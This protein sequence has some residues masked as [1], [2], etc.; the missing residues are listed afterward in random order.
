MSACEIPS[1]VVLLAETVWR[2][3]GEEDMESQVALAWLICNRAARARRHGEE[4]GCPHPDFGDG[5]I[6]A[7]CGS[8][9][10]DGGRGLPVGSGFDRDRARFNRLLAAVWAVMNGDLPDPTA[11]A[12]LFHRH[13]AT[14][15]WA[16][17]KEPS[18]LI[19]AHIFYPSGAVSAGPRQAGNPTADRCRG[20]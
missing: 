12:T 14:P 15:V 20:L 8:V 9:L 17:H 11:N 2:V 13:D 5:S 6:A 19:G 16:R 4:Y 3:V 10:N 18:A 1:A 7:A